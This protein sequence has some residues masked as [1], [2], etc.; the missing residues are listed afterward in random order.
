[1][2]GLYAETC[3]KKRPTIGSFFAKAGLILLVCVLFFFA[4]VFS[5]VNIIGYVAMLAASALLIGLF[6]IIPKFNVDYEYI[7]VDGQIDFDLILGG[8][9]RKRGMRIDFENVEVMAP[10]KS[11]E[12]DSF[13][14]QQFKL[15]DYSSH[16]KTSADRYV[17]FYRL[18]EK[19]TKIIFEPNQKLI[20]CAKQKSPRK[21]IGS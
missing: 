3:V 14:R 16:D 13:N 19:L 10:E 6:Y 1:M 4:A 15:K 20:D 18:G 7:F 8:N 9:K 5:S 12:L 21:V 17:I 2:T 11:H